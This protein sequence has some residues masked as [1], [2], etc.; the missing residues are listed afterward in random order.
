MVYNV[1]VVFGKDREYDYVLHDSEL[2]GS[3]AEAARHW[4]DR[5]FAVLECE[6]SNPVGKVLIIDKILNVAKYGGEQRFIDKKEWAGQ[7]A[8]NAALALGRDTIRVDV[9]E[10]S[11]GY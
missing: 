10:F 2:A 7:F 11:I 4:F 9:A 1:K 3:S 6:P 8:H 5:E